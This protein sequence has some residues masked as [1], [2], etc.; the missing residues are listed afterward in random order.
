MNNQFNF[1]FLFFFC[2]TLDGTATS[3]K[4]YESKEGEVIFEDNQTE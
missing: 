3:G 1:L 2:R 4:H